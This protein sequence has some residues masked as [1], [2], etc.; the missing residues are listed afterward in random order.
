MIDGLFQG[1]A[2]PTLERTVQF[3]GARHKV[4][5]HSIAN[6]STPFFKPRD[7][8][9]AQFQQALGDAIDRRRATTNPHRGDLDLRDTDQIEFHADNIT[10]T[11]G[12]THDE[13]LR[14]D[15]NNGSLERMMQRLA[16]NTMAHRMSVELLR[17]KFTQLETAIRGQ[18]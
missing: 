11:P 10:V 6:L 8:D 14:H 16:E 17:D 4:L 1:G 9:P 15:E 12:A 3:T 5:S 18:F 7:L 2:I 13:L